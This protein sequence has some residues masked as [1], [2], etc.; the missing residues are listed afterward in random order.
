MKT[1]IIVIT[2]GGDWADASVDIIRLPV[3]F[4]MD[5]V[6]AARDAWYENEYLPAYRAGGHPQ[7]ES[8]VSFAEM[9][10]G[11]T[12]A[13]DVEEWHDGPE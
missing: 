1:R 2:G 7:Y 8:L 5:D 11:A 6:Q 10:F 4:S 9:R 13:P 3:G 12:D